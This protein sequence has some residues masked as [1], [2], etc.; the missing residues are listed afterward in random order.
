MSD[1]PNAMIQ[2]KW[3]EHQVPD[4][5]GIV[6]ASGE[7]YHVDAKGLKD[8]AAEPTPSAWLDVDVMAERVLAPWPYRIKCGEASAHGSIGV[9][10]LES[11]TDRSLVWSLVS[12]NSNPFDQIEMKGG[13]ILVLSTS[14]S[15][16]RFSPELKD[17]ALLVQ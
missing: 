4:F 3:K 13:H 7:I 1:D 11:T 6:R 17:A 10:V 16:F 5:D 9:V 12:Y 2:A 14:G 8:T 15:V